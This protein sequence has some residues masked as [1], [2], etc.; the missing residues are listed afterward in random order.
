MLLV[1][2]YR[3]DTAALCRQKVFASVTEW[4]RAVCEWVQGKE[5]VRL[6]IR[7]HP[8]ERI[9]EY[10]GTDDW[11][12]LLGGFPEFGKRIRFVAAE[13]NINTYDL[14]A[15]ARVVLPFTSRVGMEA[16]MMGKA[17][18]L[19]SNCFYGQCG[20][21]A[22]ADGAEE[23]FRQ[24]GQAI[25]GRLSPNE[26]ARR[27]AAL[28]YYLTERGLSVATCFTPQPHDFRTWTSKSVSELWSESAQRTI[29]EIM[30]S[31]EPV[32]VV[33]ERNINQACGNHY[34]Q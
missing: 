28:C 29:L 12:E 15:S 30:T 13:D 24:V 8:C 23:Y 10:R 3:A 22:E 31:R 2:N 16:A 25:E 21:T 19:G 20:F 18:V 11:R 26:D 27:A 4:V 9:P 14:M 5:G 34:H 6:A 1:L 7:Q 33:I 32:P 17:V